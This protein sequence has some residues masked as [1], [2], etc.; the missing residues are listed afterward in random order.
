MGRRITDAT[1]LMAAT[2]GL[3]A[4]GRLDGASIVSALD[5]SRAELIELFRIAAQLQ[6]GRL[7]APTALRGKIV[8]TAFFEPSTRTRLSFESAAHRLG[9]AVMSIPDARFTSVHKGESLADTGVMFNAYADVVVLR[10]TDERS[11]D[12]IRAIGMTVPLINGGNGRAEHPTQA[13]GDWYALVKWR[14]EL[15]DDDPPAARR[16]SPRPA[17]SSSIA[18]TPRP[19]AVPS[20]CRNIGV[21][22]A[23]TFPEREQNPRKASGTGPRPR[24][25]Q[26]GAQDPPHVPG[27]WTA[28]PRS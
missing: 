3:A 22:H 8:L 13:M 18:V 1:S 27:E 24:T 20:A 10:H 11:V 23:D 15:A 14:P 26:E 16:I 28:A 21:P 12:L 2:D 4:L 7:R 6:V 25:A 9:A 17:S 19:K 5:L